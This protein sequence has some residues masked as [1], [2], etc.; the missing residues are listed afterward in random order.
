MRKLVLFLFVALF[1]GC[2]NNSQN[3]QKSSNLQTSKPRDIKLENLEKECF[4]GKKEACKEL[5]DSLQS[6]GEFEEAA[7]IYDY[8]CVKFQYIPACLSLAHLFETGKGV[9]QDP[10]VAKDIYTRACYS[11]DKQSCTKIR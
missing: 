7:K 3:L 5:A 9:K 8:T 11:G 2:A 10:N 4:N 6:K 1:L